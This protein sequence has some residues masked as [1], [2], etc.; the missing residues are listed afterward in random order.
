[1]AT[2]LEMRLDMQYR[3]KKLSMYIVYRE[4]RK[5]Y[6]M[7]NIVSCII[8]LGHDPGRTFRPSMVASSAAI[9]SWESMFSSRKAEKSV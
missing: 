6:K 4:K 3:V 8:L 1:M 5:E 9:W 7:R 2:Q